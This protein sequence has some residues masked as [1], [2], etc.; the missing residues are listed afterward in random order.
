MPASSRLSEQDLPDEVKFLEQ[1][2]RFAIAVKE[3]IEMPDRDI[4]LLRSFLKQGRGQL[5]K[6]ARENEFRALRDDEASHVERLYEEFFGN[7]NY[8][9]IEP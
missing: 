4:E 9:R 8:G 1:F 7:A 5:S 6:R 2:D 3:L